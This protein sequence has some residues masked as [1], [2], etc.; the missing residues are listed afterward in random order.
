MTLVLMLADSYI[1][2]DL[3]EVILVCMNSVNKQNIW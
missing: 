3:D 1:Q 2:R